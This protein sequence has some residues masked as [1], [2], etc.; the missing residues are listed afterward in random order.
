MGRDNLGDRL[1]RG[2]THLLEM[3]MSQPYSTEP[4]TK[5]DEVFRKI[6]MR[7]IHCLVVD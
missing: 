7:T 2:V 5:I 6:P 1:K 3:K 4:V